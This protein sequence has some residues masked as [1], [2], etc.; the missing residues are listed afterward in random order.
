MGSNKIFKIVLGVLFIAFG[1]NI[2]MGTNRT[3]S[4]DEEAYNEVV[5]IMVTVD[6][7]ERISGENDGKVIAVS[8]K[9]N[10]DD[11]LV[12]DELTGFG[13]GAAY[14]QRKVESYQWVKDCGENGDD[15]KYKKEWS[16]EKVDSSTYDDEHQNSDKWSHESK[17]IFDDHAT[18]GVYS[19]SEEIAKQLPLYENTH[20]SFIGTKNNEWENREGYF[21][22]ASSDEPKIG[23]IRIKYYY[24]E[25]EE[26]SILAKLN[27]STLEPYIAKN[28]RPVSVVH[29]GKYDA[30]AL[31]KMYHNHSTLSNIIMTILGLALAAVG[32]FFFVDVFGKKKATK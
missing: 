17:D 19:L 1:A 26:V 31:L 4:D 5:T 20:N 3:K 23:D 30:E 10:R 15:C 12:M 24:S 8:G 27:G 16:A 11:L 6:A 29:K 32:I 7:N 25:D 14:L 28:G 21:Y 18:I 13:V 22:N 2:I 9:L